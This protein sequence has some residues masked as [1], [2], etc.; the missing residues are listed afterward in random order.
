MKTAK[1]LF[2]F[3]FGIFLISS[4][5]AIN[6]YGTWVPYSTNPNAEITFGESINFEAGFNPGMAPP[7]N[8]NIILYKSGDPIYPFTS[9]PIST[10]QNYY[11][12]TFTINSS[13]YQTY[14]IGTYTIIISGW[15]NAGQ[16]MSETLTLTINPVEEPEPPENNPPVLNP[17]PNQQINETDSYSY[18]VIATDADNDSLTFSLTQT[19]STPNWLSISSSGL[20]T[21][22]APEVYSDIDFDI[23]VVVSDGEDFD[24]QSYTLTVK[25]IPETEPE[26]PEEDTTPPV[27]NITNPQNTTYASHR[28]QLSYTVSDDVNVSSCWY[29]L[30]NGQTNI[31]TECALV[32][33]DIQSVN[34]T[35]T[36]TVYANDTSGNVG[37]ASVTFAVNIIDSEPDDNGGKKVSGK[38]S[39][40]NYK[41]IDEEKYFEQL[42]KEQPIIDL[43]EPI[44]EEKINW[45]I[46]LFV[47]IVLVLITGVIIILVI[48]LKN[49]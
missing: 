44:Q 49:K 23:E 43:E 17:I 3:I 7:N 14:G 33:T 1:I 9:T 21:G 6:V 10:N 47:T 11:F 12:D 28:T 42:N 22:T 24:T 46:F 30:D 20:I 4:I 16:S 8:L 19:P 41:D 13:I 26:E 2:L 27:I 25:N 18:Q 31:T 38:K 36:W 40:F 29:S 34:G 45:Q 37:S 15:D 48:L 5:S 35:N 39:S 32:I